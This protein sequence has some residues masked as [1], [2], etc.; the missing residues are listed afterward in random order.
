M[1]NIAKKIGDCKAMIDIG[2][3]NHFSNGDQDRNRDRD[4]DLNVGDRAHALPNL[5]IK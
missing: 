1:E 3:A 4:R 2:I 5:H